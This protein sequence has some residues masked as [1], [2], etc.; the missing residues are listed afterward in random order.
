MNDKIRVEDGAVK[1]APFTWNLKTVTIEVLI[2]ICQ[3]DA[4]RRLRK[5]WR[6]RGRSDLDVVFTMILCGTN[7]FI[8]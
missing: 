4:D 6:T 5:K 7:F 1:I 2:Q 3:T 8:W